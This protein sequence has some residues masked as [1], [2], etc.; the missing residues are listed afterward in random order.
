MPGVGWFNVVLV[1]TAS[2]MSVREFLP[3]IAIM[4]IS[5]LLVIV[6]IAIL[7]NRMVLTPL[8]R[9]TDASRAVADGR[10]DVTLEVVKEDEIGELTG[11]FNA[12][13]RTILDYTNN[14][15]VMVRERTEELAAANRMLEASQQRITESIRYARMI[16][17][18]ILPDSRLLEDCLGRHFILF[19]PKEMVGGIFTTCALSPTTS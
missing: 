13:T 2:V 19:R 10:Y 16:Q 11:T 4:L 15:E 17:S 8:T 18:S 7:M 1:D 14:L 9:L 12:M 3:I 6:T 5:L